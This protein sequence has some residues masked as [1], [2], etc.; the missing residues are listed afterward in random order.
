MLN[1]EE[2]G[3][4]RP[5]VERSFLGTEMRAETYDKLKKLIKKHSGEQVEVDIGTVPE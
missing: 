5:A 3:M 2:I 4:R 1:P